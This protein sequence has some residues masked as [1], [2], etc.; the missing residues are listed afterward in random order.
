MSESQIPV[1]EKRSE[2]VPKLQ[3]GS[4]CAS[5]V[6]KSGICGRLA[7]SASRKW[8]GAQG[9]ILV[10]LTNTSVWFFRIAG[11]AEVAAT[12]CCHCSKRLL[13]ID[14]EPASQRRRCRSACT[15]DALRPSLGQ[16]LPHYFNVV[17]VDE[18]APFFERLRT[19]PRS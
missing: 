7:Q 13:Q 16:T 11:R 1:Y 5:D 3:F 9:P 18:G 6:I 10:S 19:L 15:S 8:A 4:A 2:N 14:L 17:A 12:S